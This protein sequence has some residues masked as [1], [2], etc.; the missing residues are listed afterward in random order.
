MRCFHLGLAALAAP[1]LFSLVLSADSGRPDFSGAWQ[2]NPTKSQIDDG[3]AVT[4][5]IQKISDKIKLVRVVREKDGKEITSQFVCATSGGDC[6]FDEGEH[7]AKVSLWYDG[8]ALIV[9]RPTDQRKTPSP[10]GRW[11]WRPTQIP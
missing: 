7:K 11:N 4:L 2:M 10:N 6:E 5:T 9:L 1:L 8:K 3:R